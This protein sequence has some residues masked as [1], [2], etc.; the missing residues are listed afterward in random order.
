MTKE[1][2]YQEA[3]LKSLGNNSTGTRMDVIYL[4]MDQYAEEKAI[5]FSNWKDKLTPTQRCTLW[6]PAGSG[7]AT[8]LYEKSDDDLYDTF[9][10]ST[11]LK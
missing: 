4:A 8:G 9:L 10:K 1:E 2:I 7:S 6:P 5:S 11:N 3:T